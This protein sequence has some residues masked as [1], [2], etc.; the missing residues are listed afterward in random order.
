MKKPIVVSIICLLLAVPCAGRIIIVDDDGWADFTTIQAAIDDSNDGDI[1]VLFPG[2]YRGAGNR[3]IDFKGKAVTVRSVWPED[4]YIVA[5]TVIDC[6]HAGRGFY[7]HKYEDKDSV[8]D[9]ITVV[10]GQTDIGAAIW[11][12]SA[13]PT[14]NNCIFTGNTASDRGGAFYCQEGSPEV[15]NCT[16]I[17]NIAGVEG[18]GIYCLQYSNLIISN[19]TIARNSAVRGSGI[20]CYKGGLTITQCTITGNEA[21]N[22]GGVYSYQSNPRITSCLMSGNNALSGGGVYCYASNPDMLNCTISGNS[23][24]NSG[25]GIFCG[26][27]SPVLTNCIFWANTVGGLINQSTQIFGGPPNVTFSCIQDNDPN[28]GSIPFGGTTNGNIDDNPMFVRD[29]NDGGDGWGTGNNDD[30]GD[31]HL[32]TGSPCINAGDPYFPS[33]GQKDIDGQPRIMGQRVDMGADEFLIKMIVVT[34]PQGKEI[35]AAGSIH[36]T[37]WESDMY[38]GDVDVLLSQDGGNNWQSVKTGMS[39]TGSYMWQLPQ[40]VD[41]NQCMISAVPSVPDPNVV[42]IKSGLFTIHPDSIGPAVQSRWKTLGG[43]FERTGLSKD[44]GPQFG[45]IKWR[46]KTK[47]AVPSS[48]AIG[49]DDRVH[50][51][52]EDGKLYTLDPNGSLLW[53][54]DANSPLISS[55]TIGP[56]GSV[57]VGSASGTLHVISPD[58]SI[59]WTHDTD[60]PIYS[61]PAVS[62]AGNVFFGSSDG[63]LYAL[64]QNGSELW[65]FQTTGSGRLPTGAIFASPAIGIDGT[66]YIGGLYDPNLYALD[67]NDGSLK[68]VRN[69]QYPTDPRDPNSSREGGWPFASPVIGADGTIY[70]TLLYDSNLYAIDPNN[71]TIIWQTNLANPSSGWFDP[72]YAKDYGDAD[73]WSEPALGPDGTIYVSVD[74]PYLRAV[75]P[76]GSIKC[77]ALLGTSGGFTLTVGNDGLIYAASDGG[78]LYVVDQ[79]GWEVAHFQSDDWLNYPVIARDNVIILTD[80]NDKSLLITDQNNIVWAIGP[81][82]EGGPQGQSDLKLVEDLNADGVVNFV[83]LAILADDWLTCV[84]PGLPCSYKGRQTYLPGDVKGD[85]Y[86]F[87]DDLA[88]IADRWLND[89]R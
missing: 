5:A 83:D 76:N 23:A 35:L 85:R 84:D 56:D 38:A 7:F 88:A 67:P 41:S 42:C 74:D 18:G 53:S 21:Q 55:P 4:S 31:L 51:A 81:P 50:I 46:F 40:Q 17:G 75:D 1:I 43:S 30:F 6:E 48:V 12:Q 77:V 20:Y 63:S 54:Y 57:Y 65:T 3:D 33:S 58:G 49:P 89:E 68:W 78:Y 61:S 60:G 72:N 11:F 22:G 28:D 2:T 69:F 62:P 39:H 86:I 13:G 19:C 52:C 64:A 32:K 26:T 71:G 79:S 27:S 25:G 45:C 9:G 70:Q 15:T 82:P 8:L 37:T 10:N 29:P 73:G 59:R 47:G 36:K 16:I 24:N 14:V 80:A 87:F 44:Y 66:V 34:E